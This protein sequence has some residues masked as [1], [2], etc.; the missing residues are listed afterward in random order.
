LYDFS[1]PAVSTQSAFAGLAFAGAA[2]SL[3]SLLML[4]EQQYKTK[5]WSHAPATVVSQTFKRDPAL[6]RD[7]V[8]TRG[9]RSRSDR[10]MVLA[11]R[12]K[13]N[14]QTVNA[15]AARHR[16]ASG[17]VQNGDTLHI[18]YDPLDMTKVD[19]PVARFDQIA[20]FIA[21]GIGALMMTAGL[22]GYRRQR[23]DDSWSLGQR[24]DHF[25]AKI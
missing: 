22:I 4:D 10:T 1:D 15:E 21:Q 24:V 6:K 5:N 9:R 12:F 13:V 25:K 7:S 2:V 11:I 3:L 18:V 19:R 20:F 23:D 17:S 8:W 16:I 14:D